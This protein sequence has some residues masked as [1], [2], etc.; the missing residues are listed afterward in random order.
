MGIDW[1][2]DL[3]IVISGSLSAVAL[4]IIIVILLL[5]YRRV[6]SILDSIKKITRKVQEVSTYV[7]DEVVKPVTQVVTLIEGIRQ[8]VDGVRKVFGKKEKRRKK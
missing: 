4:I 5:M 6:K 3:V 8:G 1:F 7:G 2:R